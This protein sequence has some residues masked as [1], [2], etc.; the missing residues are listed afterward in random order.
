MMNGADNDR[1][2]HVCLTGGWFSSDNVGD[3]AILLG[4]TD[5]FSAHFQPRYSVITAAPQKVRSQHGLPAFAP[6]KTPLKLV[7][8]LLSADALVFTGGT[9][10]YDAK[11]H[12]SYYA[13]LAKLAHARGILL[14]E[15]TTELQFCLR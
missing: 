6:K 15:L 1:Q 5:S 4:I 12:M 3:Q 10:F 9:P 7:K 8:N 13:A 2:T 14:L 11:P